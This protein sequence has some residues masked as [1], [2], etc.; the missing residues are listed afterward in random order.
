MCAGQSQNHAYGATGDQLSLTGTKRWALRSCPLSPLAFLRDF[1]RASVDCHQSTRRCAEFFLRRTNPCKKVLTARHIE[2]ASTERTSSLQFRVAP[3]LPHL[4]T[5]WIGFRT[6]LAC[7]C[8]HTR[9]ADPG[10][11]G[12]QRGKGED[13][14]E[15][16]R[17][18][19]SYQYRKQQ[20][21]CCQ[22]RTGAECGA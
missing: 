20:A 14:R 5:Q 16:C 17:R 18:H 8:G 3:A 13:A 4:A 15:C 7:D 6:V 9:N 10:C 2:A 19:R 11:R 1:A 22:C 21:A 12:E